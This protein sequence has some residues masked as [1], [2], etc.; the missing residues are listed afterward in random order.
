MNNSIIMNIL[1][2]ITSFARPM[3]GLDVEKIECENADGETYT[4]ETISDPDEDEV[5]LLNYDGTCFQNSRRHAQILDVEVETLDVDTTIVSRW[6]AVLPWFLG[7]GSHLT[8]TMRSVQIAVAFW[9]GQK[10]SYIPAVY[11]ISWVAD[12][13]G[14]PV[15]LHKT[16]ITRVKNLGVAT[17]S[18]Y[19]GHIEKAKGGASK[20]NQQAIQQKCWEFFFSGGLLANLSVDQ[21]VLAESMA[22]LGSKTSENLCTTDSQID[23]KEKLIVGF[24]EVQAHIDDFCAP[25]TREAKLEVSNRKLKSELAARG[26]Q[27]TSLQADMAEQQRKADE[28]AAESDRKF[29]EMQ[30]MFQQMMADKKG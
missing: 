3:D 26:A 21:R 22:G 30:A 27:M 5:F 10:N 24:D 7:K 11:R 6:A 18:V 16:S 20:A 23:Y 9:N 15:D 19:L 14:L 28:R 13:N 8:E 25:P 1:A 29:A 2:L 4:I 17:P 12:E